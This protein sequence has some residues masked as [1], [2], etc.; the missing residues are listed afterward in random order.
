MSTV[1]VRELRSV[2]RLAPLYARAVRPRRR[3]SGPPPRAEL[4]VTARPDARHVRRYARVCGFAEGPWL[5]LTYP[6]VVAFPLSMALMARRDFPY[7]LLGLVH[8]A[9]RV[10]RVRPLEA[11]ES[12]TYRV[13]LG[14]TV[15]HRRGTAFE[16]LAEA[17]DPTGVVW[18]S[19]STYLHRGRPTDGASGAPSG[20][21]AAA[22]PAAHHDAAA[23]GPDPAA[24][25]D[26]G[27]PDRDER[28]RVPAGTGRAYASATGDRNP[29]HLHPLTARPFGFPRAIVHG[30]WSKARCLAALEDVLPPACRAEVSFRAPVPLPAHVRFTAVRAAGGHRFAL[31]SPDGDREHLR[32]LLTPADPG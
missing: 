15:P 3:A 26:E 10:E 6:H 16:V 5:P 14:D 21:G 27:A 7:P 13:R 9:N 24:G 25:P 18:R 12:L 19:A 2:P 32:G 4:L 30:M 20:G 28:W 17:A 1:P 8:V 29:I 22:G 31:R 11:T 23:A